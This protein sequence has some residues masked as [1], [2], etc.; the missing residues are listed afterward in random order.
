MLKVEIKWQK[1]GEEHIWLAAIS[2]E[3]FL[4]TVSRDGSKNNKVH[5][6]AVAQ[7]NM[8]ASSLLAGK[9][10]WPRLPSRESHRP[11]H[12]WEKGEKSLKASQSP[13]PSMCLVGTATAAAFFSAPFASRQMEEGGCHPCQCKWV[14]PMA[15]GQSAIFSPQSSAPIPA[16]LMDH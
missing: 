13:F 1:S 12:C 4:V 7:S 15:A 2:K 3:V 16:E 8:T 14:P 5:F 11:F 6:T 10:V 9:C